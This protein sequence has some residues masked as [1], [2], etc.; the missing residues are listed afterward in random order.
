M[1]IP[2][3]VPRYPTQPYPSTRPTQS[4]T[5]P[6]TPIHPKRHSDTT[7]YPL[8]RAIVQTNWYLYIMRIFAISSWHFNSLLS[9][10]SRR[11]ALFYLL[12][13]STGSAGAIDLGVV[14]SNFQ[15]ARSASRPHLATS[16][17]LG[18]YSTSSK[19]RTSRAIQLRT[20]Y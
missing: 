18:L 12:I 1:Y 10:D 3:R 9:Q 19:R 5:R 16:P 17:L 4:H 6:P 14:S 8:Q 15:R 20:S 7:R 2:N 11:R 13:F